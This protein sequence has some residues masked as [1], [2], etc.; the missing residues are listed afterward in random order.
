MKILEVTGKIPSTK[1][2][3]SIPLDGKNLILTG[4]N[5]SGKTFFLKNLFS[6]IQHVSD[7]GQT[8]DE[9]IQALRKSYQIYKLEHISNRTGPGI[10]VKQ[11]IKHLRKADEELTVSLKDAKEF[12]ASIK[13]SAAVLKFFE[14]SRQSNISA[15]RHIFGLSHAREAGLGMMHDNVS[16]ML[17]EHLISLANRRANLLTTKNDKAFIRINSFLVEFEENLKFLMEDNSTNLEYDLEKTAIKIHRTGKPSIN[18]QSLSSGYS[19]IF[20][21][22]SELILRCEYLGI[23]PAQL[24]GI[25]FIDELE[26]HLHVSLQRLILP[27]LNRSFPN[28]QYIIT[29]HSPFILT[30]TDNAVIFDLTSNEVVEEDIS[31]YSYSA[32]MQGLLGTKPTSIVLDQTIRKLSYLLDSKDDNIDEIKNLASKLKDSLE[33]LDTPSKIVYQL[34]VN[35]IL[36][37]DSSDV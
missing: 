24:G 34:S 12:R 3:I 19:A 2:K 5:G 25:V 10:E 28:I 36:E 33:S 18:L 8:R 26:A 16:G 20:S 7:G 29:T 4:R 32:V 37:R 11:I 23:E 13:N 15:T 21:F 6:K 31:L 17:E 22:Y 27:F 14:A 30:S 1:N 9:V 35:K